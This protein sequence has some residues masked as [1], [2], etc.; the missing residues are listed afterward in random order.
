MAARILLVEDVDELRSVVKQVIGLRAGLEVVGEAGDGRSAIELAGALQPD[1]VVLDLGLPDLAGREVLT[2]LRA[3]APGA[4]VVIYSG[5]HTADRRDLA[6]RAEGYV[7]KD[8]EVT[9]LVDLLADISRR[10]YKAA[11]QAFEGELTDV[12]RAREFLRAQCSVWGCGRV[13]DNA[14]VVLSELV[15]NAIVHVRGRV[16]VRLVLVDNVLRMEVTDAGGGAP[17][18]Q[19]PGPG[20]DHGRG[21]L[22]VNGLSASW[23]VDTLADGKCV[24]AEVNIPRGGGGRGAAGPG[25]HSYSLSRVAAH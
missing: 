21:L 2:A 18:L 8:R 10:H 4:Q 22:L 6:Q 11:Y 9:Y 3:A 15:S 16:A 19:A 13:L 1:V 25:F 12:G 23:G 14:L 17:D 5:T 24:W 7:S 20:E